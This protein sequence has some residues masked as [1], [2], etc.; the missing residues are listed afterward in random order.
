MHKISICRLLSH[1]QDIDNIPISNIRGLSWQK[2]QKECKS[3]RL[4]RSRAKQGLLEM[5]GLLHLGTHSSFRCQHKYYT[6]YS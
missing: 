6:S 2:G 5:T 4:V 1:K 3:Q